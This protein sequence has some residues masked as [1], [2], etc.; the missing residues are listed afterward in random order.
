MRLYLGVQKKKRIDVGVSQQNKLFKM[1]IY[2]LI[3]KGICNI[4]LLNELYIA[5]HGSGNILVFIT[6]FGKL[7]LLGTIKFIRFFYY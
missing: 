1:K 5:W 7:K 4:K 2:F 3:H 6:K